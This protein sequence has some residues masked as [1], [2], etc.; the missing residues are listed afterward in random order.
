[1]VRRQMVALRNMLVPDPCVPSL[2]KE[3]GS[4]WSGVSC[5]RMDCRGNGG[6][7]EAVPNQALPANSIPA[8][9][10]LSYRVV[11]AAGIPLSERTAL[12]D[13]EGFKTVIYR[14]KM[15]TSI[16]A[17]IAAVNKVKPCRQPLIGVSSSPSLPVISKPERSKVLFMPWFSPE[18]TANDVHKS[19]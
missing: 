4:Q 16:P 8:G 10:T 9:T 12:P 11:A 15:A 13:P 14:K 5:L 2:R 1:M 19:S 18:F 3:C 6:W 7:S 17:E